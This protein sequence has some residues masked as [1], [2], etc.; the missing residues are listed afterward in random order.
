MLRVR[1]EGES[2]KREPAGAPLERSDKVTLWIVGVG[3]LALVA[4]LARSA[5]D[6]LALIVIA[7]SLFALERTVGDWLSD[8]L[9]P[10]LSRVVFVGGVGVVTAVMLSFDP[11]RDRIWS[12]LEKADA[13]GFHSVIV[14]HLSRMPGPRPIQG[15]SIHGGGGLPP[16]ARVGQSTSPR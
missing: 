14:E 13:A 3:A 11:V 9:G 1:P 8:A 10:F 16:P 5:V 12:G 6:A 4:L 2:G 7:I 15:G